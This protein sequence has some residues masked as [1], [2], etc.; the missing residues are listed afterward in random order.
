MM[1]TLGICPFTNGEALA[2]LPMGKVRY[3]ASSCKLPE[4]AWRDFWYE[5]IVLQE[6][7]PKEVSTTLLVCPEFCVGEIEGYLSFT[8]TLAGTLE[9]LKM[10]D[11]MQL[12][13]FHP[14]WSFRDGADRAS[15][16]GN[17]AR[18]SPYPML[19]LLRTDQVRRAQKGIPTGLVYKQNDAILGEIGEA[20]LTEMMVSGSWEAGVEGHEVDRS[21]YEALAAARRMQKGES[22]GV[23]GGVGDDVKKRGGGE[24][25]I[26]DLVGV[27]LEGMEARLG[28]GKLGVS[29]GAAVVTAI[30]ALLGRL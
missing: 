26:G 15:S 30:N 19:N 6:A 3:E 24:G 25:E 8:Q 13:F 21:E 4:E 23:E 27:I 12:V 28:G 2:G 20:A 1:S 29:E 5:V 9:L 17:F 7:D 14:L 22:S 10:E 11:L 18:R 16:A